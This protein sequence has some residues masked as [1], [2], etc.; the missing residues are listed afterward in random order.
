MV[1]VKNNVDPD[2]LAS[3]D[4]DLPCFAKSYIVLLLGKIR[5][6]EPCSIQSGHPQGTFK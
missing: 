5:F 4:F 6:F 3:Y 2:Q 1:L